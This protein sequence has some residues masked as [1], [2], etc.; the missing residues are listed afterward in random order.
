L[1]WL[2]SDEH[3]GHEAI[4]HYCNRPFDTVDEMNHAL[5]RA[6]LNAFKPGNTIW[7]LGDFGYGGTSF[8]MP[9]YHNITRGNHDRGPVSLAKAGFA[10]VV[11]EAVV[12]LDGKRILLRH[13]P[14]YDSLP[15]GIDGVFHGH[16]HNA[17][18]EDLI[19][20]KERPIVPW[21]NVN[22]C[23]EKTNYQPV[24]YKTALKMLERQRKAGV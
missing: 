12:N 24:S 14:L 22:L 17:S 9:G 3:Y 21:W 23:V 20:A 10:A 11:D 6:C 4:I 19:A 7:H 16:I 8:L 15:E 2:I 18:K 1:L 13:R 5:L